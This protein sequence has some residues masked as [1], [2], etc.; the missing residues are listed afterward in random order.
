MGMMKLVFQTSYPKYGGKQNITVSIFDF[1]TH[2]EVAMKTEIPTHPQNN[3]TTS[4]DYTMVNGVPRWTTNDRVPPTDAVKDYFIDRTPGFDK[5]AT[6]AARDAENS[7]FL[8]DY[9]K[10]MENYVPSD[11]EMFEM[12]AAFGRGTEVV[13]VITG[14]RTQL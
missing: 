11:E 7:A 14:R 2:F 3:H 6:D 9:R 13:N 12:R 10:R 8:A 5:L 4:H 1:G